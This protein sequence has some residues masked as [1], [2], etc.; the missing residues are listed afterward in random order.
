MRNK[1][2]VRL[3]ELMEEYLKYKLLILTHLELEIPL[4]LQSIS[5]MELL[6]T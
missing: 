6:K 5:E 4:D 2:E 3:M 1:L